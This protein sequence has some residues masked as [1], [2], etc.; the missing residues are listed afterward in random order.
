MGNFLNVLACFKISS[1]WKLHNCFHVNYKNENPWKRCPVCVTYSRTQ[2]KTFY[3]IVSCKRGLKLPAITL[4]VLTDMSWKVRSR[5]SVTLLGQMFKLQKVLE[6]ASTLKRKMIYWSFFLL[7][8][9]KTDHVNIMFTAYS[10]D[11][12][13]FLIMLERMGTA[14]QSYLNVTSSTYSSLQHSWVL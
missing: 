7:G 12:L 5:V 6:S 1:F 9:P 11:F 13:T 8:S 10:K 14:I 3:Y 2:R 4:K